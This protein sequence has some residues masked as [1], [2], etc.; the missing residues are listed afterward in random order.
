MA[1]R[2]LLP[3]CCSWKRRTGGVIK[4]NEVIPGAVHLGE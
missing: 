3:L 1:I 4:Q 2:E